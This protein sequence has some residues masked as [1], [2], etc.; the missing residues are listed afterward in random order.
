MMNYNYKR[1]TKE[2]GH[3]IDKAKGDNLKDF[4]IERS[5]IRSM[6]FLNIAHLVTLALY[7]WLL[8]QRVVSSIYLCDGV[9]L[10][11]GFKAC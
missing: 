9:C 10:P 4:P 2:I 3:S 1:Q 11:L 8:Q 6:I 5:R 7:D